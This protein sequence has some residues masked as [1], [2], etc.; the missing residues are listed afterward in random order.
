[1]PSFITGVVETWDRL[2][3]GLVERGFSSNTKQITEPGK[4]VIELI[5]PSATALVEIWERG[6]CLDTTIYLHASGSG[7]ILAAG[8]CKT[9]V[10]AEERLVALRAALL[11]ANNA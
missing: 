5:G 3:L 11:L 1:M 8:T 2:A 10:E 6:Q 7:S 9:H 4:A